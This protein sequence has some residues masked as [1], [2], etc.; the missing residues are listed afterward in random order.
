MGRILHSSFF[1][2]RIL[3]AQFV[4]QL[5]YRIFSSSLNRLLDLLYRNLLRRATSNLRKTL[6]AIRYVCLFIFC[7][8]IQYIISCFAA[9]LQRFP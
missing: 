5:C 4:L 9:F 2:I 8:C 3:K 1:L 6:L 7:I